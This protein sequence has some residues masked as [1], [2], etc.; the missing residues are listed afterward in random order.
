MTSE[1]TA[2]EET[3]SEE[4]GAEVEYYVISTVSGCRECGEPEVGGWPIGIARDEAQAKEIILEYVEV[5]NGRLDEVLKTITGL[6][7]TNLERKRLV[8]R[9]D[10]LSAGD[11][12]HD[13]VA[14]D[15]LPFG[16]WSDDV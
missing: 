9:E 10:G 16:D 11:A 14:A 3:A 15:P 1:E 4:N 12:N 7:R 2:S 6:T 5:Q 8:I 13:A